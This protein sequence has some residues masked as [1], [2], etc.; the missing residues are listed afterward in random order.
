MITRELTSDQ[1]TS[2][3]AALIAAALAAF[4]TPFM[5]SATNVALPAIS[6][7][8][9]MDAILLSWVR[10]AYLLAAAMFLVPFGKIADIHGR[11]RIFGYGIAIFTLAALLI[12]FSTSAPM[13]IAVRVFQGLG[14]AMIFGTSMAILTSVF[15]LGERGRILGIS[16][17]STYLGLSLGPTIG[18]LLTH[19]IGWRSIFF[20]TVGLGLIALTFVRWQLKGEWAEATG[21]TFDLVGS[22]I[23]GLAL[24]ALMYGFSRLPGLLGG[25][26]ILA[27]MVGLVFFG[28]WELRT[29]TPVLK[30]QL[31]ARNRPFA[32]SNLAA[33]IHYSATSAVAFLLSLFLQHIQGL[34]P[35]QAGLVL[36]AQPVM[37]AL[38]S[39][40]AGWLSDRI[41][42]RI[43]ASIG[44][45]F[46]S[47]G[48]GLL[49][50]LGPA[51]PLWTIVARLMVLG[52]GFAL[53][54]S[55]NTNAIMSSVEKRF[56][57]VASGMVGT[58]RL[59]GQMFSQGLATLL[60]AL[61]I[62]RVEIKPESYPLFLVSMKTAF[63][64]FAILCVIGIFASLVRG[65]IR[66]RR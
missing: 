18:G 40:L 64:I 14:S 3:R 16:V 42:P 46:T 12:G 21:E 4:L 30:V 24:V 58:M 48:L 47:A 38:F 54:S 33:L 17:A 63:I 36:I 20:L 55:P 41:E 65:N 56:Y 9:A 52:F 34:N 15:P 22:G 5:D 62:G 44:M 28:L 53:F 45:T 32:F 23:Y 51:S 39:P 19:Q 27:G 66:D 59:I 10:T 35:Q 43:V 61:Y 57:G 37:M 11:K 49:I 6:R 50:P 1:A 31:L 25:G 7:E 2:R 29:T 8:F 26:L 13:L 60:F